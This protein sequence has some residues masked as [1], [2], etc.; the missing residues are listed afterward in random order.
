MLVKPEFATDTYAV[1]NFDSNEVF[2]QFAMSGRF[3]TA[4]F[5]KI[6]K[7][8]NITEKITYLFSYILALF[9]SIFSQ[10]KLYELIEK[11]IKSAILKI[12]IPTLILL[13]TFSIELFLFIEKGIMWFGI[14]MCTLAIEKTVNFLK[15]LDSF[16]KYDRTKIRN[17]IIA[18]ILVFVANCS[19]Q[20]ITRYFC[21]NFISIC[22]KIF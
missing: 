7:I 20:G 17:L 11:D 10:I 13:N 1:F 12:I 19:Y 6:I 2:M 14:L 3:I 15:N 16:N 21:C 5:F 18:T 4:I 8:L 9:C 22:F